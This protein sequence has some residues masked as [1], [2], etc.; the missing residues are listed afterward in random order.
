MV[1]DPSVETVS[2]AAWVHSVARVPKVDVGFTVTPPTTAA[3]RV[4]VLSAVV[5]APEVQ[6]EPGSDPM[7][8]KISTNEEV[9]FFQIAK[10][11]F[12]LKFIV[13]L[14]YAVTPPGRVRAALVFRRTSVPPCA[15][16]VGP[17][18]KALSS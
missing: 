16:V 4:S 5:N 2:V 13:E 10:A 8:P 9:D 18:A 15:K 3:L 17:L 6:A 12:P 11:S 7:V 1:W 14:L